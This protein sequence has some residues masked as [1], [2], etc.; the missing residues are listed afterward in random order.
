MITTYKMKCEC[1]GDCLNF[2]ELLIRE[3]N[4][5]VNIK[6]LVDKNL[7]LTEIEFSTKLTALAIQYLIL[8]KIE[9]SYC[10]K[11]TLRIKTEYTGER[12]LNI[13]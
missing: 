7:G 1:F 4:D 13:C 5:T 12:I 10:M 8:N 3:T 2:Q 6:I 11:E 9:D